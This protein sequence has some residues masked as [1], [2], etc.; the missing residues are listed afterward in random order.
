MSDIPEEKSP[1]ALE[2]EADQS[3]SKLEDEKSEDAPKKPETPVEESLGKSEQ[4]EKPEKTRTSAARG[5][6]PDK[7]EISNSEKTPKNSDKAE[8]RPAARGKKWSFTGKCYAHQDVT[9]LIKRLTDHPMITYAVVGTDENADKSFTVEGYVELKARTRERTVR[10]I[11]GERYTPE[12][13]SKTAW[14]HFAR[15]LQRQRH[16][17]IGDRL[18]GSLV[19]SKGEGEEKNES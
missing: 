8:K 15:C 19:E 11:A 6:K 1:T 16:E 7:S 17:E 12:L 3:E 14:D 9:E 18:F 4:A 5:K 2:K 13:S 10:Q